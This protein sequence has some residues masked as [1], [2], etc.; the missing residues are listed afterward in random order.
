MPERP[1]VLYILTDQQSAFA[2]SCM[3]NA[4]LSTPAMDR[5]AESG[6]L[7]VHT[8]CTQPLCTPSRASMFT[9]LLPHQCGATRNGEPIAPR[10]RARELARVLGLNGYLCA[11]GGKWHVPE[12]EMP[13]RN[14]HGFL[15]ICGFDDLRLARACVSFLGES[16]PEPF[17]L[18][19]SF[20]NPHNICEWGRSQCLPWGAVGEP[21]PPDQC[22]D[23]PANF[24]VPPFE[25]EIIRVEQRANWAIYPVTNYTEDDWRRHRWA[26][27]RLVEKV[28]REIGLVLDG[29]RKAG[30]E[31]N[32]VVIFS[33]D[34]GDGHGAHRWNQKS[35]LYEEAVRVP[36]IVSWK[37]VTKGAVA[38]REHL[39]SNGLDLLPTI[40][41]YAGV[42]AP[43]GLAGLSLRPLAEG[44]RPRTWRREL[45][46]ETI[47]D[48]GRGYDARG[49]MLRAGQYKY[50]CYDRGKHREQLF[51]LEADPG[52]MV[53]LA[54]DPARAPVL[55]D[56][57]RRLA[58]HI[59]RTDDPFR[60]VP[61]YHDGHA[62]GR[63]G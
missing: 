38:D 48:G 61:G 31:E 14:E 60:Q 19:A 12:V 45:V 1:N 51:D 20:D 29:L 8:Y 56:M 32:T 33:S 26:Y 18:V 37:G 40:C 21:P 52:E 7:F 49:R 5:L 16:P 57:R 35:V 15:K 59:A 3:G 22:P 11:Y 41:D 10:R 4:E 2:M 24:D 47:F 25:P 27:Y 62:W 58:R 34:H 28:D 23:L 55:E 6:R 42:E 43:P 54:A 39:V 36:M 13:E 46:A 30:L 63:R 50:V 53:N 44:K 17:L 9:G